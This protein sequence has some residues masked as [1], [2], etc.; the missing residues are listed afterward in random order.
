MAI[1]V[2]KKGAVLATLVSKSRFGKEIN[3]QEYIHRHPEAIP[4]YDIQ[5]DKRLFVVARELATASGPIDALAVDQDGDIYVIETKLY[6]NADKR[7]VVAQALD[8]GASLWKHFN[9]F[10]GFITLLDSHTHSRWGIGFQEKA[11]EYFSLDG[12]GADTMLKRMRDNL[13]DGNLKFVILMDYIGERL[14]ELITYVNMKSQFDIYAV[15]LE[16]YEYEDHRIV[17]PKL[18]GVETKKSYPPQSQKSVITEHELLKLIEAS[19]PTRAKWV[20]TLFASLRAVGLRSKELGST[21]SYGID[22]DGEFV[23]LLHFQ[24]KNVYSGLPISTIRTLG[25]E[26]LVQCKQ[27]MNTLG[28]F[29]N[30]LDQDDAAKSGSKGPGY[31]MLSNDVQ[32]FIATVTAVADIVRSTSGSND[33]A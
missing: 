3:L 29:Y 18:Y 25:G 15:E 11:A 2:S 30:G 21:I 22:V 19:D 9:D 8:Y 1:I 17:L 26:R 5:E 32:S 31:G 10:T 16:L 27:M 23:P 6:A 7:R 20:E 12:F 24:A 13:R 14:K 33:T 28:P 4:I